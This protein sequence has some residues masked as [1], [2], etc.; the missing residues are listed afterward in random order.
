[1]ANSGIAA[2]SYLNEPFKLRLPGIDWLCQFIRHQGRGCL[3]YK[4]DLQW[5]YRQLPIDPQDPWLLIYW[6]AVFDT[7]WPFGVRTSPMICQRTTS[8]VI[9]IFT[10]QGYTA[11]VYLDDFYSAEDP[12]LAFTAFH[13]LQYL[14]DQLRLQCFPE[15]DSLPATTM[16]CLGIE[17]D[18]NTSLCVPP[19]SLQVSQH[20]ATLFTLI[21]FQVS[22]PII[23]IYIDRLA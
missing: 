15:K 16:V 19:A 23:L 3:I 11:D 22:K 8:S 2:S 21:Q 6:P 10:E 18:T 5:A 4:K 17:V 14:F 9:C 1:M 20:F 12:E 7:R 13:D